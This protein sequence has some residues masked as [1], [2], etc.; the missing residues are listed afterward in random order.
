MKTS[1]ILIIILAALFIGVGSSAF[2]ARLHNLPHMSRHGL[3]QDEQAAAPQKSQ[4]IREVNNQ[5][6][7]IVLPEGWKLQKPVPNISSRASAVF[8]KG[9]AVRVAV[10]F[11]KSPFQA[12]LMAEKI[13]QN[14]RK[15]GMDVSEPVEKNGLYVVDISKKGVSGRGYFGA[16][17]S[18]A[19]STII[20]APD[21]S[22]ANELLQA[23]KP[24][25]SGIMPESAN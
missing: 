6:F 7:S 3:H 23:L 9:Q 15:R 17:G 5:F 24:A 2:C 8:M 4:D 10:D 16:D 18:Q 19:A 12:K 20:F 11:F 21:I 1:R 14:M 25:V 22:E 13:S